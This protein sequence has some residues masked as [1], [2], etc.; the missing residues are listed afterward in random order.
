MTSLADRVIAALRVEHDVLVPIVSALTDDELARGSAAEQWTVAQVTSHLGSGAEIALAGLQAA[1]DGTTAPEGDFN[2]HVWDRWNAMTPR[3]QATDY[4]EHDTAL[5][6][7][8]EKLDADQRESVTFTLRFSPMPLSV[9][10]VGGLRLNEAAMHGWDVRAAADPHAI[11]L[12]ESGELLIELFA[13]D[14]SFMAGF[15]GKADRIAEPTVLSVAGSDVQVVIEDAIAVSLDATKPTT[16]TFDGPLEALARLVD[17][18]LTPKYTAA[19]IAVTGN[20]TLDD[21]R[22]AFPGF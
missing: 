11:L 17:G 16:A 19:D 4:V 7:A 9:A 3:Q 15:I 5:V 18:R 20:V 6:N 2:Q 8:F 12:A 14:L 10:A 13:G 1:V 22:A 21:L